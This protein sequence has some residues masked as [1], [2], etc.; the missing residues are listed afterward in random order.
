M[1]GLEEAEAE[2]EEGEG[3]VEDKGTAGGEMDREIGDAAKG[4]AG[5]D[6]GGKARSQ[7]GFKVNRGACETEPSLI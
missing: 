2:A 4:E 3:G 1:V 5:I 6:S 7:I